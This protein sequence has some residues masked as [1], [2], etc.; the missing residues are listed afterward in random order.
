MTR[1][2]RNE[3][4]LRTSFLQGTNAGYIEELQEQYERNPGSVSDEWRHFFESLKEEH[5][6]SRVDDQSVPVVNGNGGPSWGIPL[7]EL[8][9]HDEMIAALTGDEGPGAPQLHLRLKQRAHQAGVELSP[10]ASVRATQDSIRALM[11]IRAYRVMGHLAADLDPL[12]IADRNV[13]KELRADTY[14]FLEADLDRPV[15]LDRYLGLEFATIRQVLSILKAH[16]LPQDRLPVHAHHQPGAEIVAAAARGG[17]GKGH[18]L[19][20]AGQAR[21]FEQ[22]H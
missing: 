11:L 20:G 9:Q 21:D 12:G 10:E 14:G 17:R 8:T 5:Q 16:V 2:A 1:H 22:A 4:F 13:H 18:Y 6:R 19:Y 7:S 3:N 15:F